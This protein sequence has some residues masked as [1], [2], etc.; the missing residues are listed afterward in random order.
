MHSGIR[1]ARTVQ[2][3]VLGGH[4]PQRLFNFTLDGRIFPLSLPA[5]VARTVV[6]NNKFKVFVHFHRSK[7]M[8]NEKNDNMVDRAMDADARS[9]SLFSWEERIY[10]AGD[11][12]KA[13]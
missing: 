12:G 13:K 4:D 9:V 10:S 11:V 5:M 6:F 3:N 7:A 8:D 2:D 1:S